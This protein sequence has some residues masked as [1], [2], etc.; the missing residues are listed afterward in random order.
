[1]EAHL[2]VLSGSLSGAV[3]EM[4][5]C[6]FVKNYRPNLDQGHST[7]RQSEALPTVFPIP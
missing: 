7:R 2:K 6:S 4:W 1:M 3:F 5:T